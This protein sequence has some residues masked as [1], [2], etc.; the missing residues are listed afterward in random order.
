MESV[1]KKMVKSIFSSTS[2][3]VCF[4]LKIKYGEK[5]NT[6]CFHVCLV[7][8][9]HLRTKIGITINNCLVQMSPMP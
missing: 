8:E 6:T 5:T 2:G 3:D 9:T 1:I 7:I 4:L